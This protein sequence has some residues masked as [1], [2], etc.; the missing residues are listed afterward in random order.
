MLTGGQ[1]VAG[2]K[3]LTEHLVIL[4][5]VYVVCVPGMFFNIFCYIILNNEG[6]LLTM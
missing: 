3:I 5:V 4:S 2:F 1:P 6:F